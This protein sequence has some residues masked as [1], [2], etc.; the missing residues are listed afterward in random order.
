MP[1]FTPVSCPVSLFPESSPAGGVTTVFPVEVLA[2]LP[3][4]VLSELLDAVL[5]LLLPESSP[6]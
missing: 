1:V 4:N 6:D 3:V 5:L 2:E